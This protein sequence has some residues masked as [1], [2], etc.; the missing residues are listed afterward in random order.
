[1]EQSEKSEK[2]LNLEKNY[3]ELK[4]IKKEY[5]YNDIKDD[6]KKQWAL[7]YGFFESIQIIIDLS[8]HITVKKNLGNP[9]KYS[10]CIEL[11]GKNN[12]I[13]KELKDKLLKMIGLRNILVH[14]Y[15][16]ID[17]DKLY[18]LLDNIDDFKQFVEEIISE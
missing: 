8:C 6:L 11:L 14:E 16:E 9:G 12:Y 2:I 4:K 5:S 17:L 13:S 10:D 18:N 15:I 1:L 7:R 3:K